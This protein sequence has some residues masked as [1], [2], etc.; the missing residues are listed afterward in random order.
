MKRFA[1]REAPPRPLVAPHQRSRLILHL[2][3][4]PACTPPRPRSSPAAGNCFS[5][6][7]RRWVQGSLLLLLLLLLPDICCVP[8]FHGPSDC[9]YARPTSIAPT[10]QNAVQLAIGHLAGAG[11]QLASARKRAEMLL[12]CAPDGRESAPPAQ[13][14]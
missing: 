5:P 2:S 10:A 13:W 1:R 14:P 7:R 12:R 3:E 11:A 9:S 8:A 6:R 4:R